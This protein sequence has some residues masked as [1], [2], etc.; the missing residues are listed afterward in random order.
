[1]AEMAVGLTVTI[2]RLPFR[3]TTFT[4]SPLNFS[5]SLFMAASVSIPV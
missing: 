5:V 3:S 4:V 1:M 2:A